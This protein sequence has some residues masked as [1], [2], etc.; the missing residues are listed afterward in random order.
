MNK[1]KQTKENCNA[2]MS[3]TMRVASQITHKLTLAASIGVAAMKHHRHMFANIR[4]AIPI[5]SIHV[6]YLRHRESHN[7]RVNTN[8]RHARVSVSHRAA[9]VRRTQEIQTEKKNKK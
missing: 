5:Q 1:N 3:N 9:F 7:F 6:R 2:N 4:T 8:V